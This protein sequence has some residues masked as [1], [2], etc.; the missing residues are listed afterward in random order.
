[1]FAPGPLACALPPSSPPRATPAPPH[2]LEP[3]LAG[4]PMLPIPAAI[5]S[6]AD[7]SA[8]QREASPSSQHFF[9]LGGA[10]FVTEPRHDLDNLLARGARVKD[11]AVPGLFQFG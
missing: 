6:V 9:R 1:A 8:R 7:L 2:P 3:C 4:W 10:G 11:M 5:A